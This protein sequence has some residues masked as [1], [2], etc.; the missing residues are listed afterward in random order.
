MK[1]IYYAIEPGRSA[2]PRVLLIQPDGKGDVSVYCPPGIAEGPWIEPFPT[3]DQALDLAA[4]L[5][6]QINQPT[7]LITHDKVDWWT[8]GIALVGNSDA[9]FSDE[10]D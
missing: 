6:N 10:P 7:V 8:D 5:A 2:L 3:F 4:L 9:R 1:R